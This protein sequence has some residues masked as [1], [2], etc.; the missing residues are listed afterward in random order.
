MANEARNG[1]KSR[2]HKINNGDGRIDWWY[3]TSSPSKMRTFCGDHF[4][5]ISPFR[6]FAHLIFISPWPWPF[7]FKV[8]VWSWCGNMYYFKCLLFDNIN[9]WRNL[10]YF[11]CHKG[12][13]FFVFVM[14]ILMLFVC[15]KSKKYLTK[16]SQTPMFSA[17]TFWWPWLYFQSHSDFAVC[18]KLSHNSLC[19]Q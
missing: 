15:N 1:G 6:S 17:I 2:L 19:T 18:E 3:Y 4:S 8:I 9:F 14:C 5:L 13:E 16:V 11:V 12:L 10:P 7:I